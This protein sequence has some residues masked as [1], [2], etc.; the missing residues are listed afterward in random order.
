MT[1]PPTSNGCFLLFLRDGTRIAGE[2]RIDGTNGTRRL[3]VTTPYSKDHP[4]RLAIIAPESVARCAPCSA[5]EAAL[6]SAALRHDAPIA[7]PTYDHVPRVD[8]MPPTM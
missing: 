1:G 6:M 7:T 8:Q 2:V 3:E 4:S 5:E